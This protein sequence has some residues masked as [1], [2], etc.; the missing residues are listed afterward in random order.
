MSTRI[1]RNELKVMAIWASTSAVVALAVGAPALLHADGPTAP[2]VRAEAKPRLEVD[3]VELTV[4]I[5]G[6]KPAASDT[7]S[8]DT[9]FT[10]LTSPPKFE[11]VALNPSDSV[12]TVDVTTYLSTIAPISSMSRVPS[13]PKEAWHQ[14][15]TFTLLPH[16]TKTVTLT[17]TARLLPGSSNVVALKNGDRSVEALRFAMQGPNNLRGELSLRSGPATQPSVIVS[18]VRQ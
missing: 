15:E 9:R 18:E 17:P 7:A 8:S 14:K 5:A 1:T 11:L 3:G 12:K 16:E 10:L 4:Q 2:V 13:I 6:A